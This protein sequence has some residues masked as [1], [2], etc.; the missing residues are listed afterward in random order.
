MN[1]MRLTEQQACTVLEVTPATLSV[2]VANRRLHVTRKRTIR[3]LVIYY[4]KTEVELLKRQIQEDQEYLRKQIG[5]DKHSSRVF[6]PELVG[7]DFDTADGNGNGTGAN[8]A[9]PASVPVIERLVSLLEGL[10][11]GDNPRVPIERKLLLTMAEAAAYSGV[12]EIKLNAAIRAGHLGA[13]KDLGRG[14]RIK[15]MDLEEYIRSL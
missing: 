6:E 5:R 2:Y 7:V 13:R 9:I 4:D 1:N 3:G 11:P 12:S 15:R 10:T 8:T 14:Q